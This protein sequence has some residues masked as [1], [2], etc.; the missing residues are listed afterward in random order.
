MEFAEQSEDR[1]DRCSAFLVGAGDEV[2]GEG[3]VEVV[4]A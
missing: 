2:G 3:W 4:A 1:S